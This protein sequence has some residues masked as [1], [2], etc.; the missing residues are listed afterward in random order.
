[1]CYYIYIKK[2]KG[3][4]YKCL[5]F[6][7]IK[8]QRDKY[9]KKKIPFFIITVPHG[10]CLEEYSKNRHWCDLVAQ[11]MA[12]E[13]KTA[14]KTKQFEVELFVSDVDRHDEDMNRFHS[15]HT[16]WRQTITNLIYEK[17]EKGFDVWVLDIHSF[18]KDDPASFGES[19]FTLLDSGYLDRNRN[20]SVTPY[21]ED[22]YNFLIANKVD[23]QVV[24]GANPYSITRD[25][26]NNNDIMDEAREMNARSFL[27]ETNEGISPEEK[28]TFA[29]VLSNFFKNIYY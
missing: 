24:Q 8:M 7:F 23:V 26:Y 29:R 5:H 15:R 20:F 2:K 14:I 27:L 3:K 6:I 10:H 25:P 13:I 4:E 1:M 11:S 9:S 22:I 19:T 12:N 21:V 28:I 17:T 16:N 18:P